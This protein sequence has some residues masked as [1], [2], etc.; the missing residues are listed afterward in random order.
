MFLGSTSQQD[1]GSSK[2]SHND[3]PLYSTDADRQNH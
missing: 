3:S 2:A 1:S